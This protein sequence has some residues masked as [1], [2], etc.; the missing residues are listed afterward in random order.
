MSFKEIVKPKDHIMATKRKVFDAC[1]IPCIPYSCE[2][3]PLTK[4]HRD[5][6]ANYKRY[7]E[8]SMIRTRRQD[9][10]ISNVQLKAKIKLTD[11]LEK[12]R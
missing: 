1:I 3:W 7:M 12:W 11:I 2:T 5:K 9:N 4:Y 10:R 6:L 8:R